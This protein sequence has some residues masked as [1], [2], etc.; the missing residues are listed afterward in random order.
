MPLGTPLALL[1]WKRALSQIEAGTS[2]ILSIS[3]FD[4]IV[5]TELEKL[6]QASSCV[7][8]WNSACLSCFSWCDR[9]LVELCLEPAAFSEQ[10][11]GGV[12]APSCCDFIL[13]VIFEEGP[14]HW[15]LS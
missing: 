12:N 4:G 10:C 15:D 3:D 2:G 8:E 7:E 6:S 1:Q 11:S 9:P 13:R 5:S 14:R